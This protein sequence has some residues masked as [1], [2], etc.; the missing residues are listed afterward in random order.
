MTTL[1]K[2]V[3]R[4]TNGKLDGSY[5]PDRDKRIA[6]TL[7]P[8]DMLQLRPERTRRAE[9]IALIDVYRYAVRC[10]V[11][12]SVLERARAKKESRAIR[13]AADRQKRAEKRLIERPCE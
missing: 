9:T 7:L 8:G 2:P 1:T 13:L 11:N 12:A 4:M 6:V 10:R 3:R 5:G